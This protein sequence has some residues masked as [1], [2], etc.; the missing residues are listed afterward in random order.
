MK[1]F[2]SCISQLALQYCTT[3]IKMINVFWLY[4]L[5]AIW[6]SVLPLA[7]FMPLKENPYIVPHLNWHFASY[8]R[9]PAFLNAGICKQTLQNWLFWKPFYNFYNF[10]EFATNFYVSCKICNAN[11]CLTL[12]II[13]YTT[14]LWGNQ[15]DLSTQ[16]IE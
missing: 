9:F 5:Q 2:F 6:P 8:N 10:E 12:I 1:E 15:G 11:L 4:G 16:A 7:V 3:Y 14:T 13:P